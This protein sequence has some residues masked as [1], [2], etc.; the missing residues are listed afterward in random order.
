MG[1]FA[2]EDPRRRNVT[3]YVEVHPCHLGDAPDSGTCG[4]IVGLVERLPPGRV[5][6]DLWVGT[7]GDIVFATGFKLFVSE[8]FPTLWA[9]ADLTG[10]DGFDPVQVARVTRFG[11]G[12]KWRKLP[13]PYYYA[14]GVRSRATV[15]DARSAIKRGKKP[16]YWTCRLAPRGAGA[17]CAPSVS[18]LTG[19]L[20]PERI[21]FFPAACPASIWL[22]A[23]SRLSVM[24][25]RLR[26][27]C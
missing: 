3:D 16:T 20:G 4:G 18:S 25:T 14:S 1:F 6:H 27:G 23:G 15:D 8:R 21:C 22:R 5:G 2:S 7:F 13:P 10:L 17:A 24:S 11:R 26:M 19:A 12:K 9:D